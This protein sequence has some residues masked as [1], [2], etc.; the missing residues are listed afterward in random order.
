MQARPFRKNLLAPCERL[1]AL[2]CDPA[3]REWVMVVTL[4]AYT[5][6]W[7]LF[8]SASKATQAIYADAAEIA[9]LSRTLEWGSWK[10]PPALPAIAK[11]WFAIFPQTD[12]FYHLLAVS[13]S[14]VA[15]YVT[16][17]LAGLW[18]DKEKRAA[19]PFL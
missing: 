15:I 17:R 14:S 5:A 19:V 12:L 10:H 9:V 7:T 8:A 4:A 3:R 1:I 18:L 16:W 6:I 13:M 11:M 2:L